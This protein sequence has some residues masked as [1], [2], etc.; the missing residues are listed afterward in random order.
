M[1]V[2]ATAVLALAVSTLTLRV[3]LSVYSVSGCWR[4]KIGYETPSGCLALADKPVISVR[5]GGSD[6][7]SMAAHGC[8]S[9]CMLSSEKQ[10][11]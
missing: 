8:N 2:F 6:S 11:R 4:S 9:R 10:E 7:T 5:V 3:Q 1:L